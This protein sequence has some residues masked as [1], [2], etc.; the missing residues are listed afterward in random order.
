MILML[1]LMLIGCN[2]PSVVLGS[3]RENVSIHRTDKHRTDRHRGNK[4]TSRLLQKA[5]SYADSA[6]FSNING[7][8]TSGLWLWQ[9]H[10]AAISTDTI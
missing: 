2:I 6:Y 8:Y 3:T 9:I 4:Q 10:L 5:A 7:A 1:A